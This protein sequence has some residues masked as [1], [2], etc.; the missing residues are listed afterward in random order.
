MRK[1]YIVLV[2]LL[3]FPLYMFAQQNFASISFGASL[4]LGEYSLTDDLAANGYARPGGTIKF[5]AGYFPV[6]YIGI[7]GSFSFGSNYALRDSLLNSMTRYIEET[8]SSIID[9]PNDAEIHYGTGFW[10]YINLFIGPHFSIRASQRLY[11]DFRGVAGLSVIRH[12][13]QELSIVFDGT[14]IFAQNSR[15]KLAFGFDTGAGIRF[16]LNEGLALKT[17]IYYYQSKARFDYTFDLFHGVASD[18]PAINSQ[19]M[20]RTLELTAGLAYSF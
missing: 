13:D 4:P 6:S 12:P 16:K 3:G 10:N 14:E 19:F 15:T 17:G 2:M 18:V 20:L 11:F 9:I 8:A 5:D 7:G 1:R